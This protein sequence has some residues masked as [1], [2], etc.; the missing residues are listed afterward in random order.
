MT[1]S[2]HYVPHQYHDGGWTIC[3]TGGGEPDYIC[4]NS[5][6][7][8]LSGEEGERCA[9]AACDRY[10]IKNRTTTNMQMVIDRDNT[11]HCTREEH[12]WCVRNADDRLLGTGMSPREAWADAAQPLKDGLWVSV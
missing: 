1:K 8:S 9:Q 12:C 6:Y 4:I 5:W 3:A 11:A 10:N 2:R 7:T